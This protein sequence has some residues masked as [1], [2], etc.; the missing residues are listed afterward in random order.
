MRK[1]SVQHE[2][3]PRQQAMRRGC[4]HGRCWTRASRPGAC[5]LLCLFFHMLCAQF[6]STADS[7]SSLKL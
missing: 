7:C 3:L 6:T 4:T 1:G 5:L 2:Q